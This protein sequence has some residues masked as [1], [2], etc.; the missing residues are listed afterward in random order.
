MTEPIMEKISVITVYN[1]QTGAVMPYKIRW[2]GRD[3]VMKKLSYH[4][5]IRQGRTI[6]H[7]FHVTDGAMDFRLSLDTDSLHWMLEEVYSN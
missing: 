6:M 1:R 5:K 4:H 7:I 3:Y 2:Q